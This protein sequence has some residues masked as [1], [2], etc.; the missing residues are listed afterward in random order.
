MKV[1]M[2]DSQASEWIY[3]SLALVGG[4]RSPIYGEATGASLGHSKRADCGSVSDE[5]KGYHMDGDWGA[6]YVSGGDAPRT[7]PHRW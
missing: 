6:Y 4:Y 7:S 1:Q 3:G 5:F 2:A